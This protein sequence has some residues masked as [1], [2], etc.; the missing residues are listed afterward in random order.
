MILSI[1]R[2]NGVNSVGLVARR[3]KNW[4]QS[5]WTQSRAGGKCTALQRDN[6]ENLKQIFPE[7]K[8]RGL[9]P[10]FNIHMSVSEL[11]FHTIGLPILLQENMWTNPGNI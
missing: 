8:L 1:P 6:T 9:C 4:L 3:L 7:K 11:Y 2:N 5:K 10:N